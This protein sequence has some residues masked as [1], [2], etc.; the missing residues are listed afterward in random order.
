[1][2]HQRREAMKRNIAFTNKQKESPG[3]QI[4]FW[5]CWSF[6]RPLEATFS[7]IFVFFGF[8]VRRNRTLLL[9]WRLASRVMKG[10]MFPATTA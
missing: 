6:G 4:F 10:E 3:D 2:N 8:L 9:G 1:M 5:S 7:N